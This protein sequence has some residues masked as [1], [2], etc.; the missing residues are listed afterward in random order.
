M[1][2]NNRPFHATC[3]VM[4]MIEMIQI[5]KWHHLATSRER[6]SYV[7]R[8]GLATMIAVGCFKL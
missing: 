8:K 7:P 3:F 5:R 4:Q 2:V 1:R 6:V